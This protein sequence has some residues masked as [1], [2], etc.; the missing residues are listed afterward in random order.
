MGTRQKEDEASRGR[1]EIKMGRTED[2]TNRGRGEL[3]MG[4]TENRA[5]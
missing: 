3:A 1:G 4:R 5:I 2:R